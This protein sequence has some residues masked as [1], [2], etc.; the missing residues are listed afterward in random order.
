MRDRPGL[1]FETHAL[2]RRRFR[3]IGALE[4]PD[5]IA[6]SPIED[7]RLPLG[8]E[9]PEHEAPVRLFD[10]ARQL[11]DALF[12]PERPLG[13]RVVA[14]HAVGIA[15]TQ[16]GRR[17]RGK[18]P[19]P[20]K[21]QDRRVD[22]VEQIGRFVL[23]GEGPAQTAVVEDVNPRGRRGHGFIREPEE[24]ANAR[25]KELE[26]ERELGRRL[27]RQAAR[28]DE[29]PGAELDEL[30][31]VGRA[32]CAAPEQ[33]RDEER[34]CEQR[35]DPLERFRPTHPESHVG[36]LARRG[37]RDDRRSEGARRVIRGRSE[38]NRTPPP[39]LAPASAV[40]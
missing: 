3:K 35:R 13:L 20:A 34:N 39:V 33:A 32:R 24:R 40:C 22:L 27:G 15:V 10:R 4:T 17:A 25:L 30:L 29:V 38:A 12:V 19:A 5:Q 11:G 26:L 1:G 9:P 14:Q 37:G 21:D 28:Q 31:S 2:R 23:D 36:L 7:G 16:I 8:G 18:V 6:G